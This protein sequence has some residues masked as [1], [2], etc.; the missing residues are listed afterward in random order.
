MR[1]SKKEIITSLVDQARSFRF[2]GPSDDPD[3][4]T[5]VTFDFRHLVIQFKRLVGPILPEEAASR[6]DAIDVEGDNIYSAY[7]AKAELD[8]L[9][10]DIEDV[11]EQLDDSGIPIT[12]NL[13]AIDPALVTRLADIKSSQVEITPLVRMCRE[14]NSSFAQGNVLATVLL[15]RTILNYVPPVF[16]YETFDQVVAHVGKSLKENFHHLESGL[17][18][19]ADFHAHSRIRKQG[20]YPSVA[21]VDPFRPQFELLLQEV[22]ERLA[23][24]TVGG[25]PVPNTYLN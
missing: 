24:D 2:C 12:M 16:G 25:R 18:K 10:P 5:A 21:Q 1:T 6:L 8:A 23:S 15:M 17:R 22:A 13:W 19:V 20:S 3:E 9:L 11:L 7:E 4:Q 14:I